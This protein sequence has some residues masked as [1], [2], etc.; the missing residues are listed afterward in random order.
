VRDAG[1][2]YKQS[3]RIV[4]KALDGAGCSN[5]AAAHKIHVQMVI[6]QLKS[7]TS[8]RECRKSLV[9]DAGFTYEQSKRI[10]NQALDG[11]GCSNLAAMRQVAVADVIEALR[12]GASP[13]ACRSALRGKG[14][15]IKVANLIVRHAVVRT[16]GR[17][18]TREMCSIIHQLR[19][20]V[21]YRTCLSFLIDKQISKPLAKLLMRRAVRVAAA[22]CT[23]DNDFIFRAACKLL[24]DGYGLHTTV[25]PRLSLEQQ[26]PRRLIRLYTEKAALHQAYGSP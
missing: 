1:F 2:T 13:T 16:R 11:A 5:P 19:V 22:T 10:V 15:T 18:H 25:T 21:Q 14:F 4:N 6:D 23:L 9:R 3:K 7:G 8:A 20:G 24:Q 17:I 12:A 26:M